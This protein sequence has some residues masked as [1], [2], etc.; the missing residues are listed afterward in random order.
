V[1]LISGGSSPGRMQHALDAGARAYLTKP[2]DADRVLG[3]IDEV[4]ARSPSSA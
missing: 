4:L 3:L 1:V 2:L